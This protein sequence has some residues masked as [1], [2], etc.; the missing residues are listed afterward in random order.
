MPPWKDWYHCTAHTY[1]TWL[2]GDP[3]GWRSRHHREHV[4]GDYTIP[5]PKGT[6]DELFKKS[7][8]VMNRDP[9]KI[10]QDEICRF[11]LKC[12]LDR[13]QEFK[14]L[15]AIGCF[16]GIHAHVLAQYPQHNPKIV[17]GIA[18]QY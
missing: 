13:L 8:D 2:R 11:V 5:P 10:D 7:K 1:G 9:V 14:I 18:K 4:E 6:Y 16:D 15:V 17:I 12:M 3:R